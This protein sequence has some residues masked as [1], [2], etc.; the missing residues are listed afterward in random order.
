M[1]KQSGSN[2]DKIAKKG[3]IRWDYAIG[4]GTFIFVLLVSIVGGGTYRILSDRL[5]DDF[6]KLRFNV[7]GSFPVSPRLAFLDVTDSSLVR[8]GSPR[9]DRA[10]NTLVFN[11]L[12][13]L[14]VDAVL[15]D[16]NFVGY[17][18][19]EIDTALVESL[20]KVPKSILPVVIIPGV[21]PRIEAAFPELLQAAEGT[22][23]IVVEPDI[24]GIYRHYALTMKGPDGNVDSIAV[25]LLRTLGKLPD[26]TKWKTDSA[27]KIL[28]PF[29]GP[30]NKGPPHYTIDQVI[31]SLSD[32]NL[33]DELR[34]EFEGKTLV[35]SEASYSGKDYGST[36]FESTY[37]L[38]A[39][40]MN[41]LNALLLDK[42]FAP[43]SYLEK[44]I[45][46]LLALIVLLVSAKKNSWPLFICTG[47]VL[48]FII[49]LYCLFRFQFAYVLPDPFMSIMGSIIL[50]VLLTILKG[51][52]E[53]QNK[54]MMKHNLSRF[55]APSI[56]DKVLKDEDVMNRAERK[57]LAIMFT[58]I[59]GFS[60]WCSTTEP[61]EIR[62]TLNTYFNSMT[63]IVFSHGG[64]VDKFI[65]DGLLVFFGDPE[66]LENPARSAVSVAVEM[67]KAIPALSELF[68]KRNG[69]DL[70][71]RIGINY[72]PVVVGGIGS[73]Q[74][75]EYT[76][77]GTH[78]NMA[79]RLEANALP[80]GILISESVYQQLGS[81]VLNNSGFSCTDSR[82]IEL[83][84]S[85]VQT[86]Y[87][88]NLG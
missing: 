23:H 78:V 7:F 29:Y 64:T 77:L 25:A 83:K 36:P 16:I 80:G 46:L 61:E 88:L 22:G 37:P 51:L 2:T 32:E 54:E 76:V 75:L 58:D 38:G 14:D 11:A 67:Q 43:Q 30:W 31:N 53:S 49:S 41:V 8:L 81:E 63:S 57:T 19:P 24:D 56:I 15:V 66:L 65:G 59:V 26:T 69:L 84:G 1:P 9:Y 33:K 17:T 3:I 5:S 6:Q 82:E 45:L 68:K 74:I 18:T 39:L 71:I 52:T 48:P 27:G 34:N 72:G 12:A 62:S 21:K 44:I 40:H 20:G 60:A 50:F 13:N 55:F 87:Y 73:E 85:G 35:L 47:A 4:I 79:Q 70:K 42:P 86:V 10:L 28:I